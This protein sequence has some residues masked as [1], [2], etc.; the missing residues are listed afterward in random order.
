MDHQVKVRGHRIELGE[1]E[2][3][4]VGVDG[5]AAAAVIVRED[6]PGDQR[7]VAYVAAS[8]GASL[9]V[10][11][12]RPA[13]ASRLPGYMV[14][15]S[16]VV[17]DRLPL[18]P[19]RKID[20]KALPAPEH[21]PAIGSVRAEPRSELEARLAAIW[22]TVLGLERVG[23]EDSFFDLGG[24]SLLA[25][26]LVSRIRTELGLEVRVRTIFEAPTIAGLAAV[27]TAAP[28]ADSWSPPPMVKV[29]RGGPLPLSFAQ[30]RMWFLDQLVPDVA[31]YMIPVAARLR[32]PLDVAAM[33]RAVEGLVARHEALRTRIVVDADGNPRPVI[34]EPGGV[35]LDV[36]DLRAGSPAEAEVAA[37]D[38]LKALLHERIDLAKG[39]LLRATLARLADEDHLLSLVVHHVVADQ[40]SLGLM[41]HELALLYNA[42]LDG[43]DAGLPELI[44]TTWTSPPG[45]GSWLQGEV[46][47]RQLS[48]WREQLAGLTPLDLPLDRPRPA[49][50]TFAGSSLSWPLPADLIAGVERLARRE[51]VTLFA[52]LLASFSCCSPGMAIRRTSRSACRWRSAA[53]SRSSRWSGTSSTPSWCAPT[54]P[55]SRRSSS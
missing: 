31:V 13:L 34:D 12:L 51:G 42:E 22:S 39:P 10:D 28:D 11:A 47:E 46:L 44:C 6:V 45:S 48:Y 53:A 50:E 21:A 23:V 4:L 18:T 49:M 30:E 5:V 55:G 15:S 27:L 36:L 19:N 7:L 9:A 29:D 35:E 2:A 52:A 38:H 16:F 24:H 14:P 1:I 32:G 8:A 20:R 25:T 17:L 40:W 54:C 3:A 37:M 41:G 43:R 26:Q 33:A